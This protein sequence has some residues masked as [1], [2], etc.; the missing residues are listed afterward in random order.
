M[1]KTKRTSPRVRFPALEATEE[2]IKEACAE[3]G[4]GQKILIS[5]IAEDRLGCVTPEYLAG[6]IN[7]KISEKLTGV[8]GPPGP[9]PMSED[10][11]GEIPIPKHVQGAPLPPIGAGSAFAAPAGKMRKG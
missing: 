7:R 5:W 2:R 6:L 11:P 1:T 9:E 8:S 10:S 3:T 4:I